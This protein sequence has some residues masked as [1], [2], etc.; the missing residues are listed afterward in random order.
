[1]VATALM[2]ESTLG[3]EIVVPMYMLFRVEDLRL[4][5][6]SWSLASGTVNSTIY[7]FNLMELM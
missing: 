3:F 5:I 2:I 7:L 6:S 4:S 1:M